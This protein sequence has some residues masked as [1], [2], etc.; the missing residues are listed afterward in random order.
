MNIR[1]KKPSGLEIE[2]NDLDT[3]V[4]YCESLGWQRINGETPESEPSTA[5]DPGDSPEPEESQR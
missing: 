3:T 4:K 5:T 1:W 2:T